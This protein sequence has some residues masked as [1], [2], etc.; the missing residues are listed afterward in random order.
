MR[1]LITVRLSA[2]NVPSRLVIWDSSSRKQR[3]DVEASVCAQRP[4]ARTASRTRALSELLEKCSSSLRIRDFICDRKVF[5]QLASQSTD[6]RER[7]PSP[8]IPQRRP[9]LKRR[10]GRKLVPALDLSCRV[11]CRPR[12]P[13]F[14]SLLYYL[15]PF[16]LLYVYVLVLLRVAPWS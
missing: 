12:R 11:S 6:L 14:L 4:M 10:P 16:H 1:C 9:S 5:S 15:F 2:A 8:T 3:F 13:L 7:P